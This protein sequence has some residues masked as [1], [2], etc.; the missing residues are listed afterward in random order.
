[1]FISLN[2]NPGLWS[3]PLL[4]LLCIYGRSR[5]RVRVPGNHRSSARDHVWA[6]EGSAEGKTVT[7]WLDL[8]RMAE[9]RGNL[10]R[11]MT[12]THGELGE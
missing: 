8:A 7:R 1:M 4:T 9:N 12:G 11:A 5:S 6:R 10:G 3:G 2:T